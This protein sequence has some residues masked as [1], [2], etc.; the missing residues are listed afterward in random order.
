MTFL[1]D[2]EQGIKNRQAIAIK[3]ILDRGMAQDVKVWEKSSDEYSK[4]YGSASGARG[5]NYTIIQGI[6]TGD[7]FFPSDA[8]RSGTFQEGWLW[9]TA[10]SEIFTSQIIEFLDSENK[11]RKYY[12]E[13][14]ESIGKTT[15]IFR[16]YRLAAVSK[17]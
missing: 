11:S 15:E 17:K 2:V 13:F 1:K 6:G 14:G 8:L 10:D 5:E 4:A 12:V 7:D 16:R 3:Q 9:T